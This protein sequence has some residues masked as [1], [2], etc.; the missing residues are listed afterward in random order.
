MHATAKHEAMFVL[1]LLLFG[2]GGGAAGDR[3][4]AMAKALDNTKAG[5]NEKA[6]AEGMKKLKAKA[7]QNAAE[8][9]AEEVERITTLTPPLP[10]DL[11]AAC[12]DAAA[13]LD[14]FMQKRVQGDELGRWNA[15]KEPDMRK[16]TEECTTGGSIEVGAC[17]AK[18][19]R[20]A[21][22]GEFANGAQ[23]EIK[24][25]CKKRYGGAAPAASAGP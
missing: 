19:L 22:V 16:V 10:A 2:C 11:E 12:A 15:T 18:G 20:E 7:D 9:H 4:G 24:D 14:A 1:G 21:S 23:G 13:G 8:A 5:A 17:V 25:A 6:D 3:D